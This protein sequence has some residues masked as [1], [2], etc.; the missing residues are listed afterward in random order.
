LLR[1]IEPIIKKHFPKEELFLEFVPDP[2]GTLDQLLI[3]IQVDFQTN[4]EDNVLKNL[5]EIDK[6]SNQMESEKIYGKF[7]ISVESL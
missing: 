7:L 4:S 6:L 1:N 2:E 5:H 3:Y